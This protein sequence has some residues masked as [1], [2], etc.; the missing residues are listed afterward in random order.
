MSEDSSVELDSS[1]EF[2]LDLDDS[3][4][5]LGSSSVSA[6]SPVGLVGVS[7]VFALLLL[8]SGAPPAISCRK[9]YGSGCGGF[10][11]RLR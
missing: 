6:L 2:E 1:L 7:A 3:S 9:K 5:D 10:G 4:S 11:I 8:D